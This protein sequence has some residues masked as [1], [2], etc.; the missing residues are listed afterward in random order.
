MSIARVAAGGLCGL[1]LVG[2]GGCAYPI[3]KQFRLEARKDLTI[4]KVQEEP[5]EYQGLLVIWGGIILHTANDAEGTELT[6]LQMPLDS[7][8]I[9]Q[10]PTASE[11][12]FL[13]RTGQF[14]DPEVWRRGRK[15]ILA[16]EITGVESRPL[17][18]TTYAYPVLTIKQI[19]LWLPYLV[20]Q[21]YPSYWWADQGWYGPEYGYPNPYYYPY[22]YAPH[23]GVERE[24][25]EEHEEHERHR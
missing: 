25:H 12:R 4:T 3:A 13:A 10:S 19:H 21:Y 14:L 7:A 6:I 2:V 22:S 11:G 24:E 5:D 16:G 15:V 9:P 8:G 18:N 20:R 1:L 23:Y 17:G